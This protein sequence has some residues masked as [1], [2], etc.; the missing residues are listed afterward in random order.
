MMTSPYTPLNLKLH[1][2]HA[3]YFHHS[4]E[5]RGMMPVAGYNPSY[6]RRIHPADIRLLFAKLKLEDA[7]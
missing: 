2:V 1:V 6:T 4:G 5:G 3:D 7:L